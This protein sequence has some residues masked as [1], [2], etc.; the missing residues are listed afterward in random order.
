MSKRVAEGAPATDAAPAPAKKQDSG[1]LAKNT[2]ATLPVVREP[3]AFTVPG[4]RPTQSAPDARAPKPDAPKPDA[5]KPDATKPDAPKPDAC[6][7]GED[8]KTCLPC[9]QAE[10][11]T[12]KKA[13][14]D[15][16]TAVRDVE[17]RLEA[18]ANRKKSPWVAH[19]CDGCSRRN[20]PGMR[21]VCSMCYDKDFC[22]ACVAK[23]VHI[24]H[25]LIQLKYKYQKCDSGVSWGENRGWG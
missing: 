21:Y 8:A 25:A 23:D 24:E 11:A 3:G 15:A 16:E 2:D 6:P 9:V 4:P 13:R 22:E 7:H 17:R 12:Q 5:T 10:L 1:A 19:I 14:D 18:A 20:P